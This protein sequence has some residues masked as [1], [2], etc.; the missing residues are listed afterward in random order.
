[1]L[2]AF[3]LD[4]VIDE[5]VKVRDKTMDLFSPLNVEDAVIQSSTFGSPPNWHISHVT[6]FFQKIIE[7]Y[8][9]KIQIKNDINLDYL[10]SYYQVYGKILT[11]SERGRYPR[12]TVSQSIRYREE[13]E[14]SFITFLKSIEKSH[15]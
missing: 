11:K 15:F 4:N 5:F 7:K 1:M 8:N 12:P 10:N 14:K 13:V 2:S 3:L 9:G 6:W